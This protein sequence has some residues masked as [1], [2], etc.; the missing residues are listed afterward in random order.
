[1]TLG[2]LDLSI[3]T[4]QLIQQLNAYLPTSDLWRDHTF[5]INFTGLAPDAARATHEGCQV[6]VY[7]F[8]VTADRFQRNTY[9]TGGSAQR[10]PEQPLSLTL[11]YLLT[12]YEAASYVHEQQAMSIAFKC[13]HENPLVTARVGDAGA[14][15]FTLTLEPQSIDEISRLWQSIASPVRLSAVYRASVIF[16]EPPPPKVPA[17]VLVPP[18]LEAVP[19]QIRATVTAGSDGVATVVIPEAGFV[20]GAPQVYLRAA[21]LAETAAATPAP[22]EFRVV[23]PTTLA[24]RVP[25]GTARGHWLLYVRAAAGRTTMPVVLVVP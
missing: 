6:S 22:G 13:F 21:A 24:V 12:A 9:P 3:V 2:L 7:L 19:G 10:I 15:D 1:M 25:A 23:D 8:H 20:A 16:L 18:E 5:A 4:D 17:R 14:I 11:Y